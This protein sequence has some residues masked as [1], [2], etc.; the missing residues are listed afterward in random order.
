MVFTLD[1]STFA[2]SPAPKADGFSLSFD[3]LSSTAPIGDGGAFSLDFGTLLDP[4]PPKAKKPRSVPK[5]KRDP[6]DIA[7]LDM[8]TDPFD[9]VAKSSVFPFLAVLYTDQFE[10]VVIWDENIERFAEKVLDAI[11]ALPRRFVVYAHNGGKFDYM[12]L[13]KHLRGAVSFKGRGLMTA[14]IGEHELRDSFHII[15]ERLANFKKDHIDYENMKRGK[16][17]EFRKAIIDYCIAD[18][19][20]LF[21]IVKT[22]VGQFGFKLSIGQ[23]ALAA[24]K[25]RH[26]FE[27]IPEFIDRRIRNHFF[28]GR[29]ECFEGAGRF[30]GDYKLYDVNSM[31]PHVMANFQHP[32]G[33]RYTWRRGVP[34][35]ATAF[36]DVWCHSKGALV[37]RDEEGNTHA[38]HGYFRFL[39][40]IHEW[41]IAL[42]YGLVSRVKINACIDCDRFGNF[43]E[44][45]NHFYSL[46][47]VSKARLGELRRLGMEGTREYDDTVKD[48]MFYKFLLNNAFGK[49]A[50]N[51]R[52]YKEHYITDPGKRPP[53]DG[54]REWGMLP[55]IAEQSYW[56]WER[57]NPGKRFNNVGTGASITGAARAV[58][59]EAKCNAVGAIY[60]DT[61]S[62]ICRE[63]KNVEIDPVKLGAWDIEKHL[64]EVVIA[65]KKL[66]AYKEAASGKDKVKSKGASGLTFADILRLLD[67]ERVISV[68]KGVTISKTGAQHYMTRVVR[69]TAKKEPRNGW[70]DQQRSRA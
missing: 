51:A 12:F 44:F 67:G 53:A 1:F 64:S 63:L 35:D 25:D 39:T 22:F 40:T 48:D 58:L 13:L 42:K 15:P 49:F 11:A 54:E 27:K 68:A 31:Y 47:Q 52:R 20:Y 69:A 4:L 56:I 43:A 33:G 45:V 10:P 28:G 30:I 41:K 38:P 29:V 65:G 18:C 36:V 34:S 23:A 19:R 60:C 5:P 8:E 32:T 24:L 9:N 46:R 3:M 16:R 62:I 26:E 17:D 70:N 66:Y 37:R 2:S 21:D 6:N 7:V 50:Q 59:L 55:K 14:T 57:P 61:D